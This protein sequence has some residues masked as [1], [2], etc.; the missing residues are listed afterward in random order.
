M[1]DS[2]ALAMTPATTKKN[3]MTAYQVGDSVSV[4]GRQYQVEAVFPIG[5]NTARVSPWLAAQYGVRGVRG[6]LALMQ[7]QHDGIIKLI[8]TNRSNKVE[9]QYPACLATLR[10]AS[11]AVGGAETHNQEK[12]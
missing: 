5:E 11:D 2:S 3:K 7:L 10:P 9:V 12:P 8:F 1:L 6:A 4:N